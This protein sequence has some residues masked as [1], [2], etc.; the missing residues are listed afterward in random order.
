MLLILNT[1]KTLINNKTP[2]QCKTNRT[3]SDKDFTISTTLEYIN[4][5]IFWKQKLTIHLSHRVFFSQLTYYSICRPWQYLANDFDIN[6]IQ[7]CAKY[8]WI[9]N[10]LLNSNFSFINKTMLW[11]KQTFKIVNASLSNLLKVLNR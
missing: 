7:Q 4:Y 3:I 2:N 8:N 9:R 5:A 11:I 6:I 1:D 10:K